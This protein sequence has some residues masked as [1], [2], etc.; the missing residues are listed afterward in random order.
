MTGKEYRKQLKKLFKKLDLD[1]I[2]IG[3]SDIG[4]LYICNVNLDALFDDETLSYEERNK[5]WD[6]RRHY[7]IKYDKVEKHLYAEDLRQTRNRIY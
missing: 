1:D 2:E 3:P 6:D 7:V 5:I 4:G